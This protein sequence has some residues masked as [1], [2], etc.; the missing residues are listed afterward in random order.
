VLWTELLN[1]PWAAK[2]LPNTSLVAGF[3][4]QLADGGISGAT[5]HR[6][7]WRSDYSVLRRP[8]VAGGVDG[9][10]GMLGHMVSVRMDSIRTVAGEC[11][12]EENKQGQ[13]LSDGVTNVYVTGREFEDIYPVWNWRRLP[14]TIEVQVPVVPATSGA[15]ACEAFITDLHAHNKT[16]FVGGCSD[17]SVGATVMDYRS[18]GELHVH[19]SWFMFGGVVVVT[20]TG[21]TTLPTEHPVA[22]S[23]D[24]RL[25]SGDATYATRTAT[26]PFLSVPRKLGHGAAAALATTSLAFIHHSNVGYVP[27]PTPLMVAK[28][29]P[30]PIYRVMA[31]ME[32]LTG[33]WENI[34]QGDAAPV[35]KPVFAAYIDHGAASHVDVSSSYVIVPGVSASAMAAAIAELDDHLTVQPGWNASSA[36][37]VSTTA[38]QARSFQHVGSGHRRLFG[39]AGT[40]T[41]M[42]TLWRLNATA[43]A[44]AAGCWD[45]T[46]QSVESVPAAVA[47]VGAIA[48]LVPPP[49]GVGSDSRARGGCV[50]ATLPAKDMH[51]DLKNSTALSESSSTSATKCA[52]ACC[53]N[54]ACSCWTWTSDE[55]GKGPF[56]MLKSSWAPLV[57][58][59][60][61]YGGTVPNRVPPKP[62]SETT[63]VVAVISIRS[64]TLDSVERWL[65]LHVADPSALL[66]SVTIVVSGRWGGVDGQC[67]PSPLG[68]DSSQIKV[69]L[70]AADLAGSTVH[71][72]C[73]TAP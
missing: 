70:P 55:G 23:L 46:L 18:R 14:G 19:R 26:A 44:A 66:S 27:L 31:T 69:V 24:Q 63:G 64:S 49:G 52:E 6:H 5:G 53:A 20:N 9:S 16:T 11:G 54:P 60:G 37:L 4:A 36:C 48:S 3:A 25:V 65:H 22:T 50:G 43:T 28:G 42:A 29:A 40:T 15:T 67:T 71:V 38:G 56:C 12:N 47:R 2:K 58:A 41:M 32:N 21:A 51:C 39:A 1:T 17:G 61:L 13:D 35:T 33:S 10:E 30:P 7:Y 57:P 34:T 45:V 59:E 62:T 68:K 73:T 72:V 8:T